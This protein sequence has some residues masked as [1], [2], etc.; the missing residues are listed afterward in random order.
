MT[1]FVRYRRCSPQF[2][3]YC[4]GSSLIIVVRPLL[5]PIIVA[6]RPY[7]RGC[8]RR[9]SCFWPRVGDVAGGETG[10]W[11]RRKM[12]SSLISLAVEICVC[13]SLLCRCYAYRRGERHR[14]RRSEGVSIPPSAC[15]PPRVIFSF[16]LLTRACGRAPDVSGRFNGIGARAAIPACLPLL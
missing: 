16:H 3:P 5:S 1:R 8:Y 12:G 10:C 15:T 13:V 14:I 11:I 7:R 9:D 6:V 4:R 2:V